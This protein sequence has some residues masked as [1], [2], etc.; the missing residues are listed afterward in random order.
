MDIIVTKVSEIIPLL[1]YGTVGVLAKSKGDLEV[2]KPDNENVF[3]QDQLTQL[4]GGTIV[5]AFLDGGLVMFYS[6][7]GKLHGMPYNDA[8]TQMLQK[9]SDS[10]DDF[11]VGDAI[12]IN[13]KTLEK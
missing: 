7:T 1:R 10:I 12:I 4:V 11:I 5:P 6:V 2:V 8:A 9:H 3:T 13:E